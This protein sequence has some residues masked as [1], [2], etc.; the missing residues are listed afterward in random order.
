[1]PKPF[2]LIFVS[3]LILCSSVPVLAQEPD[4]TGTKW[5]LT[6]DFL[7]R[8]F[9]FLQG[10]PG[11]PVRFVEVLNEGDYKKPEHRFGWDGSYDGK[12][13]VLNDRDVNTRG[14][15]RTLDL[16]LSSDGNRLTGTETDSYLEGSEPVEFV[17]IGGSLIGPLT[18]PSEVG[19]YIKKIIGGLILVLTLILV[20][21]QL[22]K[23]NKEGPK[24]QRDYLLHLR[25]VDDRTTLDADGQDTIWVYAV[26]V[27]SDP[28]VDTNA[29]T[30]T[31]NFT[32]QGA[33]ASWL[34][35][36]QVQMIAAFKVAAVRAWPPSDKASLEDPKTTISV[37]TSVDGQTLSGV[38]NLTLNH[39]VM[40]FV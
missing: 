32:P 1:M 28:K 27:C 25:T 3:S 7:G 20:I 6:A 29:L 31:L 23:G 10:K 24:R 35:M 22:T 17:R 34:L 33:D 8:T 37:S 4:L 11:Q 16:Q 13:V 14:Q 30:S 15:T 18:S 38:I 9:T 2:A 21:Y 5:K 26:I 39:F 36:D 12:R 40:E 19:S